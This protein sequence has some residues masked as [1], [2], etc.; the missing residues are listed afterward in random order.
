MIHIFL[1][2][3]VIL[4]G[5]EACKSKY[6]NFRSKAEPEKAADAVASTSPSPSAPDLP[7]PTVTEETFKIPD[8][9][10]DAVQEGVKT[11]IPGG[12]IEVSGAVSGIWDASMSPVYVVGDLTLGAGKTLVVSSGVDVIFRGKYRLSIEGGSLKIDGKANEKVRFVAEN[13]E[14]GWAGIRMCP[15]PNCQ[16]DAIVGRLEVRFAVFENS[17]KDDL[18][19]N[20]NTWRRGGVFYIRGTVTAIIEDS[21]FLKNYSLERGG[22][23]EIIADNPNVIFRR[24]LLQ[25]NRNDGA[26]GGALLIT[27]G[28][29]ITIEGNSF[30]G[31][32]S[33][34]EGGAIYLLDSAGIAFRNNTFRENIAGESGG[35]IRCDGHGETNRIDTSN[36]M[37]GNVPNDVRCDP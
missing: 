12:G 18:N 28:R 22:A 2:S 6:L 32:Q 8:P 23:L 31:N 13:I 17:R 19:V 27:H 11:R 34:T 29:S 20:D 26:G 15:D 37:M 1:L 4:F 21:S 7:M 3:F 16:S 5:I 25:D 10:K 14:T 33:K 30:I 9:P 35:A 24:N 36:L